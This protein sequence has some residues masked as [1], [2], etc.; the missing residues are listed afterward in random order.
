MVDKQK[1]SR[2]EKFLDRVN[3][4]VSQFQWQRD[5]LS[6]LHNWIMNWKVTS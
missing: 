4:R 3:D 6:F 1:P 2:F 5:F